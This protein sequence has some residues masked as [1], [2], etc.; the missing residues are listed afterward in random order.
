MT[1]EDNNGIRLN[2]YE[3]V[4]TSGRGNEYNEAYVGLNYYICGQR[5]KVQTGLDYVW[6]KDNAN[7][8]GQYDGWTWTTGLRLSF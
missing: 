5:L 7:D 8:G 4:M 2:R 3:N 6:M 1:S